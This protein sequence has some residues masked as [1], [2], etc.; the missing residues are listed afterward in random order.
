MIA[1]STPNAAGLNIHSLCLWC[2]LQPQAPGALKA[3][4]DR[5]AAG[6]AQ[7]QLLSNFVLESDLTVRMS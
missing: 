7:R 1:R 4:L 6:A 2:F 5:Y 3:K